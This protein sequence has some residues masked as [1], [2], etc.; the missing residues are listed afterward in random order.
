MN[1]MN[2]QQLKKTIKIFLKESMNN[3]LVHYSVRLSNPYYQAEFDGPPDMSEEEM[4]NQAIELMF[5]QMNYSA[6]LHSYEI[7]Q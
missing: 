1:Q 4:L 7:K 3:E 6:K 2:K 5:K